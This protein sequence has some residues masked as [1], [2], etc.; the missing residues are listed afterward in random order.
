MEKEHFFQQ[1]VLEQVNS[2]IGWEEL[3]SLFKQ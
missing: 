1:A 2:N 3:Q